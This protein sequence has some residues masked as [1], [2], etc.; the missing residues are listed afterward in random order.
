MASQMLGINVK[1]EDQQTWDAMGEIANMIAGNFKNNL[2][3]WGIN[4]CSPFRRITGRHYTCRSMADSGPLEIMLLF[5]RQPI[6]VAV[7]IHS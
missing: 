4:A 1:D 3:V 5:E 7:E 6:N 2:L